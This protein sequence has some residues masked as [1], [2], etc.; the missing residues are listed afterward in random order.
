MK[1]I[2]KYLFMIVLTLFIT[3]MIT[4][5]SKLS[6]HVVDGKFVFDSVKP[7]TAEDLYL[8]YEN[9]YYEGFEDYDAYH[10]Y[11]LE[12]TCNSDLTKC[13]FVESVNGVET[14]KEYEIVYNYDE[15]VKKVVDRIVKNLPANKQTYE[16]TDLELVAYV[17][18][19]LPDSKIASF[20]SEIKKYIEYMN[21]SIDVRYGDGDPFI[22]LG[23]GSTIFIYDG[24]VYHFDIN[25][26]EVVSHHVF[27]VP[28][29]TTDVVSV[30][31]DRLN[32]NFAGWNFEIKEMTPEEFIEDYRQYLY[33][34]D[35]YCYNNRAACYIEPN[36]S[37]YQEMEQYSTAEA[38][39]D[40]KNQ[41]NVEHVIN[42]LYVNET[43]QSLS[44]NYHYVMNEDKIYRVF[45]NGKEIFK[46]RLPLYFIVKK[47]SSKVKDN[48]FISVDSESNVQIKTDET[49]PLDTL[50]KV[51]RI[52]SGDL[53]DKILKLLSLTDADI[54][55]LTLFSNSLGKN[56]TKLD[57]G[58]FEVGIPISD[59]LKGKKLAVYYID[60]NDNIVKFK[61]NIKDDFAIFNTNHFSVYTLA[62]D[63][64]G[65]VEAATE[66]KKINNPAT[67]DNI[68]IYIIL[69][70]VTLLG[71]A[72][73]FKRLRKTN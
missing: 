10:F 2:V 31:M 58:T 14:Q 1:K 39:A 4:N 8:I 54:F 29:D 65:V 59:K 46:D 50:I 44:E 73:T 71:S 60:E 51:S 56:I 41:Y 25:P 62:E 40:A 61:V 34:E 17:N 3:P 20:C 37:T 38:Y 72:V 24:V 30:M 33:S 47:D 42:D 23:G 67:N 35:V 64:D 18:S 13:T 11:F 69:S 21:F 45:V 48:T 63:T 70:T 66:E 55:D 9:I 28:D 43:S 36:M 22:T 15:N 26:I 19:G 5:A 12:N 53:Y 52:T 32:K 27:Y 7:K 49:I 68:G 16:L 6:D 57:N